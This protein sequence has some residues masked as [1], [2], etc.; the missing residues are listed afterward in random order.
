MLKYL[1]YNLPPAIKQMQLY[2]KTENYEYG[3]LWR[4][5]NTLSMGK[6]PEYSMIFLK[7]NWKNHR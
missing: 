2:Q 3:V 5:Q 1:K 6:I 4:L 7:F